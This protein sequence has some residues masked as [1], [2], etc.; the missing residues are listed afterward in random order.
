MGLSQVAVTAVIAMYL[1]VIFCFPAYCYLD[2]KRQADGQMDILFCCKAKNPAKTEGDDWRNV[3]LFDNFY[4]PLVLGAPGVRQF[5]HTLIWFVAGALLAV[6]AYG[7]T[8][9]QVGLGLEDLVPDTHAAHVWAITRTEELASW[10]MGMSWGANDYT[11]PD[12]QMKMI[13]QYEGVVES[14]YVANLDTDQLWMAKFLIW[15]TR[16]CDTNFQ[17]DSNPQECGMDLIYDETA[18]ETCSG[19]WTENTYGL[20]DKI[21]SD[22]TGECEPYSG[23]ICRPGSQMRE[24]DLQDINM[25]RSGG[26]FVLETDPTPSETCE[27]EY[28]KDEEIQF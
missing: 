10:P 22:D 3:M 4:K 24:D 26:N 6:G 7:I 25:T 12:V 21:I 19:I 16:H 23:G 2:M 17:L 8:Q 20:R 28:H 15:T 1:T 13:K 27:G 9:R 11:S 18:T 14:E 5:M